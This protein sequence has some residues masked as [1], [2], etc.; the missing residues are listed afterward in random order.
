L[1]NTVSLPSDPCFVATDG[2]GRFLFSAYYGAGAVAVHAI[3]PDG[4]LGQAPLQWLETAPNAH[5]IQTDRSNRFAFVPHIAGPNLILQFI[6]DQESG[7]LNPN[8]T[9]WVVPPGRVGPRHFCFHPRLDVAYFVNEQGC[10]VTAYHFDRSTG[11]LA[12]FQTLSTLPE[13][14]GAENTCAQ[15]HIT[16]A[17]SFLYAS[18]RGHDSIACFAIDPSSGRLH[19]LGQ[20]P[21]EPMPRAFNVDPDGDF[22]FASGLVSGQL[23]SYRID[24]SSG[25]L[26]PLARYRVGERPM[27]VLAVQLSRRNQDTSQ[28]DAF[29]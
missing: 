14:F 29:R 8:P 23:T 7:A 5:A 3:T 10:S 16:P 4:R 9:P 11:T 27:W 19:A 1:L 24:R 17:G 20:Q 26:Q 25:A 21:S 12:P 22:L 6:F 28:E 15:I 13:G 18:N 2:I